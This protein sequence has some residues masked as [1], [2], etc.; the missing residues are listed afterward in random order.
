[1][2]TS[3]QVQIVLVIGELLVTGRFHG[4]LLT[5]SSYECQCVLL[6]APRPPLHQGQD[7]PSLI[8]GV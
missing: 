2:Y 4:D 3:R 6:P 1:M 7:R 5:Q 8:L